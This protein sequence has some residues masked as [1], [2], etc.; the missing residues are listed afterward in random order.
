MCRSSVIKTLSKPPMAKKEKPLEASTDS[1]K[2]VKNGQ[3][4][5]AE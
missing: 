2:K 4:I 3:K 5:I 1:A